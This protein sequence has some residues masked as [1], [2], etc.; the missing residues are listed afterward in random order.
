MTAKKRN[1]FA[2]AARGNGRLICRSTSLQTTPN[3]FDPPGKT[4]TATSAGPPAYRNRR[5][6]ASIVNPVRPFASSAAAILPASATCGE[7]VLN[8]DDVHRVVRVKLAPVQHGPLEEV[9][10]SH[11]YSPSRRAR[12]SAA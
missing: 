12:M 5:C 1:G 6:P 8:V 7:R 2:R 10:P 4:S 9:E 11:R 3:G